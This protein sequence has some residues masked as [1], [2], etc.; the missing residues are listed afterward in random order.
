M[1]KTTGGAVRVARR[2]AFSD[3]GVFF[4]VGFFA[5]VRAVDFAADAG[6]LP[7]DFA[8]ADLAAE[9]F[10]AEVFAAEA[11]EVEVFEVEVFALEVFAVEDFAVV[12]AF[13][14]A[15]VFA[16]AAFAAAVFLAAAVFAGAAFFGAAAVFALLAV[17]FAGAFFAVPRVLAAFGA[18][19]FFAVVA[20][21]AARLRT[22]AGGASRCGRRLRPPMRRPF[23]TYGA[24]ISRRLPAFSS[25]RSMSYSTPSSPNRTCSP[26]GS[27]LRSSRT[28]TAVFFAT[29][30]SCARILR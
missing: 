4:A 15:G 18:A 27:P 3:G 19:A 20:P 10:G 26:A 7:V 9:V 17:D 23:S 1:E 12:E 14:A 22:G 24:R 8:G 5:D 29:D 25:E 13:F 28:C 6:L 11:F 2:G 21:E 30:T 16:G